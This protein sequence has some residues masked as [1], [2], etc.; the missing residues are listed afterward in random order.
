MRSPGGIMQDKKGNHQTLE[1]AE[2]IARLNEQSSDNP[3]QIDLEDAIG[4]MGR[5]KEIR[6]PV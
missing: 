2:I 6:I 3:D 4:K 1:Q 5:E